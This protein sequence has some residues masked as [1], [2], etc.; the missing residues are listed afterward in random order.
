M[1]RRNHRIYESP[2]PVKIKNVLIK[3]LSIVK[4]GYTE[5]FYV[6]PR[7]KEICRYEARIHHHTI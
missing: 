4:M 2:I 7:T 5:A 3:V 1:C 6:Q